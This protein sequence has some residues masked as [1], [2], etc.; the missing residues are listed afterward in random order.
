M[1][2]LAMIAAAALFSGCTEKQRARCFGG[3]ATEKLPAGQKLVTM[4]WKETHLWLL[5]RPMRSDETPETYEFRE[6]SSWG[7]IQGKV[8]LIE[9]K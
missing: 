2:I 9:S 4:T 5:T 1:K 3:T 7:I 6:S 8:I